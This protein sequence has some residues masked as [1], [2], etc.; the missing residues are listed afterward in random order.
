MNQN[1][2]PFSEI[3]A[4]LKKL[5]M[6]RVTGTLFIATKANRSA[7]VALDRGEIVFLYFFNKRG[8]EAL[9]LMSTI[10]AG[11][12][13]F[14]EG[15]VSRRCVLPSTDTLLQSLTSGENFVDQADDQPQTGPGLTKEQKN[16]LETTL[17]GYIGPM[18]GIICED[19]LGA[20][21]DLEAAINALVAELPPSVS[22]EKFR[23]MVAQ[24][25]V[26][27]S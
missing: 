26:P 23:A 8:Q 10:R 16:I 7:Q 2:I 5:C 11:R 14:Q 15:P 18:A 4:A 12:Y 13:R 9:D 6:Q 20:A 1:Y 17:A 3:V 24:K 25:L 27:Y 22:A 21:T 19:H